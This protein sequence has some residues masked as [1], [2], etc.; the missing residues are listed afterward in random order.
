[1]I[2]Y[3]IYR[4]PDAYC[5]ATCTVFP[6]RFLNPRFAPKA[7]PTLEGGRKMHITNVELEIAAAGGKER[8]VYGAAINSC[9]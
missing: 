5:T 4:L 6:L 9:G 2:F 3:A 8:L 7:T 1:M